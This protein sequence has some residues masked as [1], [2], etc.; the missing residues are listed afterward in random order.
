M[1]PRLLKKKIRNAIESR[2][3]DMKTIIL[4][5]LPDTMIRRIL[6]EKITDTEIAYANIGTILFIPAT[7]GG[8]LVVF[9]TRSEWNYV[10]D[11]GFEE[12]FNCMSGD[13]RYTV[14]EMKLEQ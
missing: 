3:D 2:V 13:D 4:K 12:L 8:T 5:G 9:D 1:T 7:D 10:T 14:T 6:P 11:E